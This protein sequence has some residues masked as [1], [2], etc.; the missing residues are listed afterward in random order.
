LAKRNRLIRYKTYNFTQID[1]IIGIIDELKVKS[2]MTNG[3]ISRAT[4]YNGG[5]RLATSTLANWDK[6]R[7]RRPQFATVAA[8]AAAMGATMLPIT[9]KARKEFRSLGAR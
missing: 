6:R 3:E 5:S 9:T 7:V 8:A 2:G 4:A 1:P